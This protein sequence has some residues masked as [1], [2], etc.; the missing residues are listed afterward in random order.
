MLTIRPMMEEELP[1]VYARVARDFPPIEYPP[2]HKMRGHVARRAVEGYLCQREGR[3]AAYALVLRAEGL[4]RA[5]LFLYAVEPALRGLGVGSEFLGALLEKYQA[6][7]G[8]YAEVEKA[9]LAPDGA[10]RSACLRRIAFYRRLGFAPVEG[11][12]YSIYGVEMH[13]FYRPLAKKE[14]PDAAA[15]VRDATALYEGILRPEERFNL[16]ARPLGGI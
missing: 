16:D 4:K 10:A 3:P 15:A 2:L 7:D 9:E 12:H 1:E 6:C 11:L 5:M 8:L 14:V 13:L